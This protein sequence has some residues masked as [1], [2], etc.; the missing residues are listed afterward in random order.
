[1]TLSTGLVVVLVLTLGATLGLTLELLV[2]V[3]LLT[4]DTVLVAGLTLSAGLA[5][6]VLA[7]TLG[8]VLDLTP[9]T[10]VSVNDRPR[11]TDD[12]SDLRAD[13]LSSVSDASVDS[14]MPKSSIKR[15]GYYQIK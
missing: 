4:L 7:L 15:G 5:V 2:V 3:T 13:L 8:A 11:C 1:M 10:A 12:S 9:V 6:T 14:E